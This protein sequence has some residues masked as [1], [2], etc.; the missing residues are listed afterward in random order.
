M[1]MYMKRSKMWRSLLKSDLNPLVIRNHL[2][3]NH[4]MLVEGAGDTTSCGN[5]DSNSDYDSLSAKLVSS[6]DDLLVWGAD[7][8]QRALSS[9]NGDGN[10]IKET[11][12]EELEELKTM[13]RA[14][15]EEYEKEIVGHKSEKP[16]PA[17][18]PTID[19]I[20]ANTGFPAETAEGAYPQIRLSTDPIKIDHEVA[21]ERFNNLNDLR[22]AENNGTAGGGFYAVFPLGLRER[23]LI[24]ETVDLPSSLTDSPFIDCLGEK[25]G[26]IFTDR[27]HWTQV[28]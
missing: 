5:E 22:R 1:D 17:L 11:Q 25:T 28:G 15:L 24:F 8:V 12:S 23:D 26:A 6:T 4:T 16:L 10:G 7:F 2:P 18:S 19:T 9:F 20:I 3:S 21:V 13:K 27:M 14:R